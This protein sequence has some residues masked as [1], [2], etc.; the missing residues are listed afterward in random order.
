MVGTHTGDGPVWE[1]AEIDDHEIIDGVPEL[2]AVEYEKEREFKMHIIALLEEYDWDVETEVSDDDDRGRIDIVAEHPAVGCIAIEV[3]RTRSYTARNIA[4]G[5]TQ[6]LNY[7]SYTYS[8]YDIDY[9][10]VAPGFDVF[11]SRYQNERE[12][13]K[14]VRN[15]FRRTLAELKL[16]MLSRRREAIAFGKQLDWGIPLREPESLTDDDLDTINE[17]IASRVWD[18]SEYDPRE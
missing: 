11:V 3:K 8:N 4:E 5:I 7:R 2:T 15:M 10:A 18:A 13:Q 16:G 14:Q 17:K 1:D 6:I 9:W 12:R